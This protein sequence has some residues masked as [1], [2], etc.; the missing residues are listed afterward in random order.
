M[1]IGNRKKKEEY[2]PFYYTLLEKARHPVRIDWQQF[3]TEKSQSPTR[4]SNPACPDRMLLLHHLCHHLFQ[5]FCCQCCCCWCCLNFNLMG[6]MGNV[7]WRKKSF[8]GKN[9]ICKKILSHKLYRRSRKLFGKVWLFVERVMR[10]I[11]MTNCQSAK[12]Q[13]VWFCSLLHH[14]NKKKLN[15]LILHPSV[16]IIFLSIKNFVL[17]YR[18]FH[19][20]VTIQDS[21]HRQ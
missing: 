10:R 8:I 20:Q 1:M 13:A 4:D 3:W 5:L 19:F 21:N 11:K 16:G 12:C 15:C 7:P 9:C 6:K 14:C 2:A 18:S 17:F